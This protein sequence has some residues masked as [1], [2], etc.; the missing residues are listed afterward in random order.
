MC[1]IAGGIALTR[2]ARVERER[3]C[4]M[5]GLLAHR[6]PDAQGFWSDPSG[7]AALAHRRLSVIDLA[8]GAQPMVSES[9]KTAIVFNG[10][11]YDY[12]EQRAALMRAGVT[13]RTQ[14]DTEVLPQLYER[15]GANC[16]DH[17]RGM[18]AFAA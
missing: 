18:F 12:R 4:R 3:L 13:F 5:A 2:D 17:L 16:V 14:S 8:G 6:G 7:R 10:E 11:I 9:G 1:G 15:Y